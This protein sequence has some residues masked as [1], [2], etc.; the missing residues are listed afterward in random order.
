MFI[1]F[2]FLIYFYLF[3]FVIY[4]FLRVYWPYIVGTIWYLTIE[5]TE[6]DLNDLHLDQDR[7]SSG[8]GENERQR[9]YLVMLASCTG[10][11]KLCRFIK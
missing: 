8:G 3:L 11:R 2:I 1:Y 4:L 9:S 5:M 6:K 7:K 10:V